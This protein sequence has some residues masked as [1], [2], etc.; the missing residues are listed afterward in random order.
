VPA[1]RL[2]REIPRVRALD[3][4][5]VFLSLALRVTWNVTWQR[6]LAA[7]SLPAVYAARTALVTRGKS[8]RLG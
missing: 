8:L 7:S 2:R 5:M 4:V 1:K 3:V 6:R